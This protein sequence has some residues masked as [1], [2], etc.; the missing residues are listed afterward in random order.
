MTLL[1]EY[2][3]PGNVRQLANVIEHSVI[4]CQGGQI[5]QEH[6]PDEILQAPPDSFLLTLHDCSLSSAEAA[7]ILA[8][9]ED[10]DWHLTQAAEALCVARGTLYSKMKRYRIQKPA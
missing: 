3:W 5:L 8:A 2:A 1:C 7:L 10:N 9:L 6:L 4:F